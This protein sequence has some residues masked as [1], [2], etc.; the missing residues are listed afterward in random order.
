MV[1][2]I[3]A[4]QDPSGGASPRG[5]QAGPGGRGGPFTLGPMEVPTPT[6]DQLDRADPRSADPEGRGAAVYF[7][8]GCHTCHAADGNM[9]GDLGLRSGGS[10]EDARAVRQGRSGMPAYSEAQITDAE[11]GDL[12]AYLRTIG[13]TRRGGSD[14]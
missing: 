5:G 6:T 2:Y 14:R 4:L 12:Q 11:L 1:S 3:R 13:A 7:A 8:Q 9:P 10:P